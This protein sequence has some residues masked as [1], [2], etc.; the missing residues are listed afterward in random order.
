MVKAYYLNAGERL[1][2]DDQEDENIL[3]LKHSKV[4]LLFLS[5]DYYKLICR[6]I[7][8]G[9][10]LIGKGKQYDLF[11]GSILSHYLLWAWK[12]YNEEH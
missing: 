7:L 12:L 11:I 4:E 8:V 10:I 3:K 2:L 1:D 9:P 5:Q 6:L